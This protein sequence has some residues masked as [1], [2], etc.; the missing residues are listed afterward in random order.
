[1]IISRPLA[2]T[3]LGI[4]QSLVTAGDWNQWRGPQRD[5]QSPASALPRVLVGNV[6]LVWE[7]PH[8]PRYGGPIVYARL[9]V[10]TETVD[11]SE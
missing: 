1:M 3:V 9:L 8:Q 6:Q 2:T 5:G 10:T 4:V 11:R 7:R